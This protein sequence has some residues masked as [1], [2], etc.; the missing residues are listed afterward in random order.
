MKL[1]ALASLGLITVALAS[2]YGARKLTE[3]EAIAVA[4]QI[5]IYDVGPDVR[6]IERVTFTEETK[7]S[8]SSVKL[9]DRFDFVNDYYYRETIDLPS[10]IRKEWCFKKDNKYYD[11]ISNRDGQKT[12]EVDEKFLF[13]KFEFIKMKIVTDASSINSSLV[14]TITVKEFEDRKDEYYSEGEGSLKMYQKS[15][16][17]KYSFELHIVDYFP[18]YS[19]T[20]FDGD[21]YSS[22]VDLGKCELIYPTAK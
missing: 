21:A 9:V 3:E 20:T 19:C 17:G 4:Q 5:A 16:Q 14:K 8:S 13:E 11:V 18:M 10:G 1:K 22:K 12:E 2:C 7:T 15:E 6:K